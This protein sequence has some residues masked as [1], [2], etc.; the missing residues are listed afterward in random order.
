MNNKSP[1][2]SVFMITYN[3]EKYITQAIESVLMQKTRFKYEIIIGDDY[4]TDNTQNIIKWYVNK[5]P[6]VIKPIFQ[7]KNIGPM[8]NAYEYTYP[9]CQGKYIAIL[10]GDDFWIDPLKLQKQVEILENHPEY[11]LVF[12]SRNVIDFNNKF[13]QTSRYNKLIYDTN[14]VLKG[15]VA[16]T[17]T[18]VLRNF[19]D[20]PIFINR[21][22]S[23]PS[24][25]ILLT[26][27]CSLFGNL[28]Y[29]DNI[30]AV[31]RI[32]S[33]GV[34]TSLSFDESNKPFLKNY[35]YFYKMIGLKENNYLLAEHGMSCFL[36]A[37]K[38]NIKN[39]YL[40][41]KNIDKWYIY[42]LKPF[43]IIYLFLS[44]NY[45]TWR[46]FLKQIKISKST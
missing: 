28:Y 23:F 20:L 13:I 16:P 37:I 10:E 39:P 45:I 7:K 33:K 36:Y 32:T 5:Y 19:H 6:Y 11:S 35:N 43:N 2:V 27:F 21:H 15:F 25:D 8:R 9:N 29:L 17:Q 4:S 26:Y 38:S 44:F 18:I 31:Y 1:L 41:I 42:L 12:T 24:G 30:T 3:H 14:D 46:Y 22:K 34:V 40:I